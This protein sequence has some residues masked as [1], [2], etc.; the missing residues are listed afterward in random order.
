M[1]RISSSK[2][3][4]FI[5]PDEFQALAKESDLELA[6]MDEMQRLCQQALYRK[7][8]FVTYHIRSQEFKTTLAAILPTQNLDSQFLFRLTLIK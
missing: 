4:K 2:S 3:N 6:A 5:A 7:G 1:T 8:I